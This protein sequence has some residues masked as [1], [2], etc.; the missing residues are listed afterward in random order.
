MLC[1]D[2]IGSYDLQQIRDK[3]ITTIPTL[4]SIADLESWLNAQPCTAAVQVGQYLLK[5]NPPRREILVAFRQHDGSVLQ[6]IIVIDEI[7][8]LTLQ[9][10]EMRDV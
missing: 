6:Q 9:F 5:T 8:P 10:H 1:G 4:H 7:D 2:T 3:L